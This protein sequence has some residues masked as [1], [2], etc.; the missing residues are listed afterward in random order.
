MQTK[1]AH[2]KHRQVQRNIPRLK[3][4]AYDVNEIWLFDV[5]Y[6]DK[7]TKDNNGVKYL[8]VA[9]ESLSRYLRGQ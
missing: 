1:N 7:V 6:T 4:L 3:V 2:K 9:V 8:L 5:A